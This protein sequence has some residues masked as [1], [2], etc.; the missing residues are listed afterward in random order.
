MLLEATTTFR[1]TTIVLEQV[2]TKAPLPKRRCSLLQLPY[3]SKLKYNMTTY[4]NLMGHQTI[5]DVYENV[6]TFREL[7]D[8]ECYRHAY[9]FIC[10]ILQ[11]S[12][13]KGASTDEM[14]LPCRN[15]CRDFMS[16]CGNRLSESIK[17]MLDCSKFPEYNCVA[18]PGKNL[19]IS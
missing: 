4:P 12:C 7:V 14:V 17:E 9:D 5:E 8:A 19:L 11:P 2:N 1:P 13:T 15:F 3:C 16:G 10:Q 6:I 18:K